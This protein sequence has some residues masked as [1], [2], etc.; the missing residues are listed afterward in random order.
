MSLDDSKPP[1]SEEMQSYMTVEMAH[2]VFQE[3]LSR[4]KNDIIQ[5][6]K[7]CALGV[8]ESIRQAYASD[9]SPSVFIVCGH[10]FN[11]LVGLF[12]AIH[13]KEMQYEPVI[14]SVYACKYIDIPDFCSRHQIPL[15]DFVPNALHSYFQVVVDALLCFGFDGEDIRPQ[16]WPIF[17]MLIS[18]TLPVVSIDIP[19]GWDLS[20]GP[21][22]VDRTADTFIKPHLIVSLGAPILAT[23]LFKGP[24]HYIASCNVPHLYFTEHSISIPAFPAQRSAVLFSSSPFTTFGNGEA[25]MHP[26]TFNAT[27]YTKNPTREWVDLDDHMDL[28]DELD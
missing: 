21:R 28:W 16:Y 20:L 13:L 19:S 1:E 6:A 17:E 9:S 22:Q 7:T 15:Y 2:Q 25:Y 23:K 18:T 14:Y 24:F 26:G 5:H 12:T 4:S 11:A 10:G 27:L 3:G 8:A